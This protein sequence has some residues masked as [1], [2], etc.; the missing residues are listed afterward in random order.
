MMLI[1][2]PIIL[3]SCI[4]SPVYGGICIRTANME[5]RFNPHI[6]ISSLP[7]YTTGTRFGDSQLIRKLSNGE[8]LY[9]NI[10]SLANRI[11]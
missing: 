6:H 3:D 4:V 2:E 8:V 1:T 9:S 10:P 11:R 7:V 5:K